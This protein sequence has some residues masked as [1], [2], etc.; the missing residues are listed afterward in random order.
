VAELN[1]RNLDLA[2]EHL[3]KADKLA[4]NREDIRYA[5]AAAHALQG[6]TDAALEHLKAAVALRPGNRFQARYDGDF[7]SLA[8]DPR[9]RSLVYSQAS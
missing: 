5:L 6:N 1:A 2:L 4:P 8:A 7:R 9:F 3:N